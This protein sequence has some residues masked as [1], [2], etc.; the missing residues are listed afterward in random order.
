MTHPFPASLADV[1][2]AWF[3]QCLAE[4]FPGTEVTS[5][6]SGTVISGTATKVEYHLT[7][8]AAGQAHGL[9]PSLW[10]KCGLETQIPEQ[11]M[12]SSFE[13]AFF[14]DL[15]PRLGVNLPRPYATA[16]A[17]DWSSGVVIYEDLNL[18]PVKFAQQIGSLTPGAML[19]LLDQLAALHASTWRDP[20]LDSLD[21]LTPGGVIHSNGVLKRFSGFWDYVSPLPRFAHVPTELRDRERLL[22]ANMALLAAD[23]ADPVCVVHGDPHIGNMFFDL[24]GGPGLLDWATVMRGHWAWDVGYAMVINQSVEQRRALQHGQLA[25]YLA[26]L[27]ELGVAAPDHTLAWRDYSRHSVYL[28][29]FVLCPP[30]L[31]P[32]ELCTQSAERACAA[33]CD[34]NGLGLIE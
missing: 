2:P 3:G 27:A 25:H 26:R 22:K 1:S 5:L 16:F 9:P 33:I 30:E 14:R 24:G 20:K 32:E 15:A 17:P 18:R 13:A 12:H 8:N 19:K 23:M 21:W 31:Q 34:L 11:A 7:Y 6:K 4:H 10:L 28:F 29:N